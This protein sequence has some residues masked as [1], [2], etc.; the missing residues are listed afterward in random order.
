[1]A[2]RA[3]RLE[4]LKTFLLA[5]AELGFF[6]PGE[7][8]V[9]GELWEFT[10]TVLDGFHAC[11]G[12]Q[13]TLFPGADYAHPP[14]PSPLPASALAALANVDD[15]DDDEEEDDASEAD[16]VSHALLFVAMRRFASL[17]FV[18][19]SLIPTK[20]SFLW[21]SGWRRWIAVGDRAAATVP[22]GPRALAA[23]QRSGGGS[24]GVRHHHPRPALARPLEK[25]MA[26]ASVR[27][28]SHG[29]E[30][31]RQIGRTT[32]EAPRGLVRAQPDSR[33]AGSSRLETERIYGIERNERERTSTKHK[34]SSTKSK[35]R[36]SRESKRILH[37]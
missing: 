3:Y 8:T 31:R 24:A 21:C 36:R 18:F 30:P 25:E 20:N 28:K 33:I 32:P 35:T 1:M 7:Q 29:V 17:I 2:H 14:S 13:Q 15:V 19:G 23:R 22:V 10:W 9:G 11:D 4:Y 27:G 12:L 16:L 37:V 34:K 5:M 26:K 6:T